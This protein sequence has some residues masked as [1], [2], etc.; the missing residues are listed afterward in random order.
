MT[1]EDRRV[2][3]VRWGVG[4]GRYSDEFAKKCL[5]THSLPFNSAAISL[6]FVTRELSALLSLNLVVGSIFSLALSFFH[7]S[8]PM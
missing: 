7:E 1:F 3:R 8:E 4:G 5:A 6:D 2:E